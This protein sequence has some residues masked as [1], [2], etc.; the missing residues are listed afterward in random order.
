[1][2]KKL[3][4][5]NYLKH[6]ILSFGGQL[7]F[8]LANFLLF[9]LLVNKIPQ[10]Q[11]GTWALYITIISISDSIRQGMVQN[12]LARLI[13]QFPQDRKLPATGFVLNYALI[14]ILG[15]LIFL[16]ALC[17]SFGASIDALLP[18]AGK[19]LM[20]IGTIQFISTLCQARLNFK[21]YFI[22]NLIYLACFIISLVYLNQVSETISLTQIINAQLISLI[23]PII[24]FLSTSKRALIL[25]TRQHLKALLDF[26]RYSTGTNLLSILFHK[27]DILMI[28]YFL[29]PVSVALFHFASK[30]M[31][32]AELPLHAL[33]QVIYPRLSASY[34]H[35]N[36]NELNKEY[37]L[38][39]IRLLVLVI[40]IAI[41]V[42]MF[43]S[44]IIRLLSSDEYITSSQL[45]IIL[46]IGIIFKP[47]GRVF[48]LTLDA[49]G[50]PKVNFRMLLLSLFINIT[51]NLIL[52]PLYGL[53]GAA[54]ATTSSI[55]ITTIIGQFRI[56]AY[57]AI[58]PI[59]DVWMAL[60]SQFSNLKSLS[61]N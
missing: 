52:I 12:G 54:I 25:P 56:E 36:S 3:R 48:G 4:E 19:S 1:M 33:S 15:G 31:N 46:G 13:I 9:I 5:S 11:F 38:S 55:L 34:R 24:Y 39:I 40:P 61:W 8:L 27:A 50:K 59:Q 44:Q 45:I 60:K 21:T 26:G 51:M 20:V 57:A 23:V 17:F 18:H 35:S 41:V 22:T 58:N 30:I 37:G 2:I 47:W 16:V 53:Q 7:S 43:N 32:Y 10:D 14:A 28:A 6:S 29:D 42:I 49:I